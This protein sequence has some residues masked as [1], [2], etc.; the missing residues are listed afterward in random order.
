MRR[1]LRFSVIGLAILAGLFVGATG[2]FAGTSVGSFEIDGNTLDS[3][4]GEPI[5]W[6][7][8]PPNLTTFT[9]DNGDTQFGGGSKWDDQATW[10]TAG[11]PNTG[12]VTGKSDIKGGAIAFRTLTNPTTN[13]DEQ[14]A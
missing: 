12:S 7:T 11:C 8:P 10:T 9:D 3:P 4:A 2:V 14:F 13:Q 1:K 6:S 5:D